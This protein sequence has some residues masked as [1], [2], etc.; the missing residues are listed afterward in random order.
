MP[1][2]TTPDNIVYPVVGDAMSPL[3]GWFAQLASSTQAAITALRSSLTQ[4][5]LPAPLSV[6]NGAVTD[7]TATAWADVPNLTAIT[8]TLSQ[9]CW[10]TITLGSRIIAAGNAGLSVSARVTGATTL[11][12]TQLEVG[13]GTNDF[14]QVMYTDGS[15][16]TRQ[17]VAT[18]T[19]R[20]N[21]GTNTITARA[22][23]TGTDSTRVAYPALQVS[24]IRWA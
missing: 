8:L 22:F 14:G 9:A 23:K 4:A 7:V 20:L 12:E 5:P 2:S 19:V 1:A 6:S 21:A 15:T 10:V 3:N 16:Q 18:R 17:S 24:P 13:G 11:G